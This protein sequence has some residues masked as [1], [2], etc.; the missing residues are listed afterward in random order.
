[1]VLDTHPDG[2]AVAQIDGLRVPL[3]PYVAALLSILMADGGAAPDHLVGWKSVAAIQAALKERTKQ[4]HTKAAVKELVYRLR[5]LLEDHDED[6]SLVQYKRHF[7]YRFA[8]RRGVSP[9]T[10]SDNL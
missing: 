8:L 5:K 9:K 10:E 3:P 4:N 1:M 2:S 7:G 6:P